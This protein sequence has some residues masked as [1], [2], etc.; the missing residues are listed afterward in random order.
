MKDYSGAERKSW[1]GRGIV[2][3]RPWNSECSLTELLFFRA[4]DG[5]RCAH[6]GGKQLR[7]LPNF[8]VNLACDLGKAGQQ[9]LQCGKLQQRMTPE[10]ILATGWGGVVHGWGIS[11]WP[12][13]SGRKWDGWCSLQVCCTV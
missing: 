10:A 12:G 8:L 11:H 4:K 7:Y 2:K 5:K 9:W 3:K 13:R 1:R 6:C